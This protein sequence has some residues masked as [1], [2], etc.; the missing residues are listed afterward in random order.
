MSDPGQF[1]ILQ[2]GPPPPEAL[3]AQRREQAE[4]WK[5]RRNVIRFAAILCTCRLS[6]WWAFDAV[7]VPPQNDCMIHGT[8]M[9][10]PDGSQVL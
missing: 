5:A 4:M 8:F 9:L 10:S 1:Q 2:P 3:A 7:P 6:P